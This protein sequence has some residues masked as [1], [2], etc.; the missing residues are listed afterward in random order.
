M[1][2]SSSFKTNFYIGDQ[3]KNVTWEEMK[4]MC[5]RMN[6]SLLNFDSRTVEKQVTMH[7]GLYM[8]N[9]VNSDFPNVFFYGLQIRPANTSTVSFT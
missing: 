7:L 1:Y 8:E 3:I 4:A 2:F 9:K 5:E 6:R